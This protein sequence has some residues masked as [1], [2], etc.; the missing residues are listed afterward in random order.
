MSL[1]GST[2]ILIKKIF[3]YYRN[4]YLYGQVSRIIN[5]TIET[6]VSNSAVIENALMNGY[7]LKMGR[8]TRIKVKVSAMRI[9]SPLILNPLDYLTSYNGIYFYYGGNNPVIIYRSSDVYEIEIIVSYESKRTFDFYADKNMFHIIDTSGGISS[10]IA[11]MTIDK[12]K[13]SYNYYQEGQ[14]EVKKAIK[15]NHTDD[16][17]VFM[18]FLSDY[19]MDYYNLYEN[20]CDLINNSNIICRDLEHMKDFYECVVYVNGFMGYTLLF[21]EKKFKELYCDPEEPTM[22]RFE[23]IPATNVVPDIR[24]L[25]HISND[26]QNF[27]NLEIIDYIDPYR[28]IIYSEKKETVSDIK[29][30]ARIS[31]YDSGV[32]KTE[33]VRWIILKEMGHMLKD[34][35]VRTYKIDRLW[36]HVVS[37][38]SDY[39]DSSSLLFR[40]KN[41]F[42][43]FIFNLVL[44]NNVE[45][46]IESLIN[47]NIK[48]VE[49]YPISIQIKVKIS[50]R[51]KDAVIDTYHKFLI[52]KYKDKF[53]DKI[54]LNDFLHYLNSISNVEYVSL[55]EVYITDENGNNMLFNMN[56]SNIVEYTLISEKNHYNN[57]NEMIKNIKY[58]S[59]IDIYF[60]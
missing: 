20:L 43:R 28:D 41:I 24:S 4:N 60:Y 54:V 11:V 52:S 14:I 6:A 42:S 7:S 36:F 3:D 56:I 29:E 37:Y 45:D 9:D 55:L 49:P 31:K 25:I 46:D 58:I 53:I 48:F 10:D 16:I 59:N 13:G 18:S 1:S 47:N 40:L 5:S 32:I 23:Y 27:K 22:L 26:L 50:S 57:I 8:N 44:F 30:K 21:S 12:I 15:F 35:Y 38:I 39:L 17:D 19:F 2:Y 34:V 51:N 33:N